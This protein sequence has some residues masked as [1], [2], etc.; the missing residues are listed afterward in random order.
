MTY[1]IDYIRRDLFE[2]NQ[3]L[4]TIRSQIK[5]VSMH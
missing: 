3:G 2:T 4:K 5:T 1:I